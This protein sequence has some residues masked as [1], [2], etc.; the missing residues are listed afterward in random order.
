MT[1]KDIEAA[2]VVLGH[3]GPNLPTTINLRSSS[4]SYSKLGQPL[5]QALRSSQASLQALD[6]SFTDLQDA[7]GVA[8]IEGLAMTHASSLK[9]LILT[10]NKLGAQTSIALGKALVDV[11]LIE[12]ALGQNGDIQNEGVEALVPGLRVCKTLTHLDLGTTG[13]KC[14]GVRPINR[15]NPNYRNHLNDP[16]NPNNPK[17]PEEP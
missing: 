4:L 3:D 5:I 2:I 11:P 8:L 9:R 1:Q 7:E 15:N 6:L 16:N 17:Y 12:L 13:M 14:D 10:F